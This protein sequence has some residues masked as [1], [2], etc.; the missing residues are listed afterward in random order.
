MG[1][2]VAR[3]GYGHEW[4]VEHAVD[5]NRPLSN[6]LRFELIGADNLCVWHVRLLSHVQ[7]KRQPKAEPIAVALAKMHVSPNENAVDAD[8]N[9]K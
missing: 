4:N 8:L 7:S 3:I 1:G 6:T 2:W 5:Y 9:I